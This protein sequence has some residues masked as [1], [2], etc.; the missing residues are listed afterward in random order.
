MKLINLALHSA[1]LLTCSL[2][3]TATAP[4]MAA[5]TTTQ[6]TKTYQS[7]FDDYKPLSED[8]LSDWKSINVPSN[9][10]GHAGHSM[11]GMQHK[12]PP[13]QMANMPSDSKEMPIMVYGP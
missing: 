8:S 6:E 2:V 13:E 4:V 11:V 5:D 9:G 1:C 7:S 3:L 10:G 12:M